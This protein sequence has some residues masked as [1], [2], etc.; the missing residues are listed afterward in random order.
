MNISHN[1]ET[2]NLSWI[3]IGGHAKYFIQTYSNEDI[4]DAL[5]FCASK[6]IKYRFIG[7]GTNIYF[8]KYFD[9]AIIKMC[10]NDEDT[11]K[12][13]IIMIMA[14]ILMNI[15]LLLQHISILCR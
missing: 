11:S 7:S 5:N 15:I 12:K 9:G 3:H 13:N 1:Y 4:L 8:G 10:L 2:H 14:I 6:K